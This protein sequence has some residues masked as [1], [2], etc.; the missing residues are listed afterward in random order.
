MA[1]HVTYFEV[2]GKDGDALQKF[3]S[4]AL[5]WK[6]DP[7]PVPGYGFV[8][9]SSKVLMRGGIGTAPPRSPS[10]VKFYVQTDDMKATLRKIEKAGGKV[11]M[12]P[13]QIGGSTIALFADPE[14]HV[15]GLL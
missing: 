14:G 10:G 2:T 4:A 7:A 9:S 5:G 11:L 12:P 3:Y 15:V 8:H 1:N 13:T 6:I